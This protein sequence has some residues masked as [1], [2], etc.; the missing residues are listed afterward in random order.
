MLTFTLFQ[1]CWFRCPELMVNFQLFD[2]RAAPAPLPPRT[3]WPVAPSPGT[4]E[5]RRAWLAR[6]ASQPQ[7]ADI[8]A[9]IPCFLSIWPATG[10]QPQEHGLSQRRF[11][12]KGFVDQ[13]HFLGFVRPDSHLTRGLPEDLHP[14]PSQ[15]LNISKGFLIPM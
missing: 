1:D 14:F 4:T 8:P 5:K 9:D 2:P 10:S 7:P 6:G 3:S 12:L 11:V 15:G 13:D